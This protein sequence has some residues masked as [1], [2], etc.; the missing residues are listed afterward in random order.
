MLTF[1]SKPEEMKNVPDFPGLVVSSLG[2][3][4]SSGW[5]A[6]DSVGGGLV[7]LD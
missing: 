6:F 3:S 4:F 2:S 7:R 5:G 1:L